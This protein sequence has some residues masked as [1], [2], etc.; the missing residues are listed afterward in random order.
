MSEEADVARA[1]QA[2]ECQRDVPCREA[3]NGHGQ[4]ADEAEWHDSICALAKIY[5]LLSMSFS[6]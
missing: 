4:S 5:R 1:L 6:M 3:N 2:K